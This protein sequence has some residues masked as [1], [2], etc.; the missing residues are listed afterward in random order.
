M[1]FTVAT[2]ILASSITATAGSLRNPA[3]AAPSASHRGLAVSMKDRSEL[4]AALKERRASKKQ[5]GKVIHNLQNKLKRSE[6][7]NLA[8]EDGDL[9]ADLDI[10]AFSRDL[11]SNVTEPEVETTVIDELVALCSANNTDPEFSCTCSNLD[12]DAYTASVTCAYAQ[13]CLDPTQNSC[14]DNATFC[15]V[16]TY[17]LEVTASGSGSSSICY[18]VT[19]PMA[20][21][22]CY[23]LTYTGE[24]VPSG[25]FLEIDGNQC[26]SCDFTVSEVYSNVTCNVFDCSN[27]DEA[28]GSGT[29]CGD[30]TIVAEKIEAYLTYGPLPCDGGCNICPLDGEMGNLDNSVSMITGDTYYCYQLNLAAQLGYLADI[31][32]DLCNS[33]PAIV[34]EP[35][36][37]FGGDGT[38]APVTPTVPAPTTAVAPTPTVPVEA[39][40]KAPTVAP[41][42]AV[43]TGAPTSAARNT[44]INGFAIAAALATTVISWMMV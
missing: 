23:G 32:G 37:C 21:D 19:A 17:N 11:Q 6:I 40:V 24:E 13:N 9:S 44:S 7:R 43:D 8:K 42:D 20:F 31:P 18:N 14:G 35:C 5:N 1:K 38:A 10:G 16:E 15:F 27:A 34:N 30:D 4:S 39:P 12:P 3:D 22:Y 28:I 29:V 36:G 33:L 26:N 41:A 2:A 25:C